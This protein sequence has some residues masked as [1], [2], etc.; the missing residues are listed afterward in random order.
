MDVSS[1]AEIEREFSERVNRIV[2]CSVAT[3]DAKGRPRSRILHPY[4]QGQV[5]WI[6]TSRDSYKAA[7]LARNPHVSLAY[8]AD[9]SKPVYIDATAE[10]MDDAATKQYVWD[11]YTNTP[12]PLGY[13][14]ADFWGAVDSPS[15]GVLRLTP[16]RI[17]VT[18]FPVGTRVW[19]SAQQ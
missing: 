18:D 14:V 7:H 13:K 10:W 15:F 8:V 2:W 6:A 19:R 9:I 11:L 4:W 3:V 5:G 1:F 16:W 12:P 17:E